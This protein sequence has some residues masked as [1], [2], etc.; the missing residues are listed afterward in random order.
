M[1]TNVKTHIII[2][3]SEIELILKSLVHRRVGIPVTLAYTEL[4][5]TKA[6][7]ELKAYHFECDHGETEETTKKE[8]QE[9]C[10]MHPMHGTSL[11]GKQQRSFQ[12]QRRSD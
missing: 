7:I 2:T 6:G 5:Q 12:D 11:G 3:K 9:K 8:V 10:E 1:K 4:E